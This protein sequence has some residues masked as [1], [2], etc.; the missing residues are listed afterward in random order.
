[1][2]RQNVRNVSFNE[3]Q[4][5]AML[6]AVAAFAASRGDNFRPDYNRLLHLSFLWDESGAEA[7]DAL[8]QSLERGLAL[9][10]EDWNE[11]RALEARALEKDLLTRILRM[12]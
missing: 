6:E 5:D 11:S 4:A 1:M 10:L 12:E 8:A 3:D 7:D 9:A 2:Q